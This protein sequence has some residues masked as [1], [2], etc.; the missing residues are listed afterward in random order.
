MIPTM[1]EQIELFD[2]PVVDVSTQEAFCHAVTE[3][4]LDDQSLVWAQRRAFMANASSYVII[5]V[6][7]LTI[8]PKWRHYVDAQGLIDVIAASPKHDLFVKLYDDRVVKAAQHVSELLSDTEI[9][10]LYSYYN[11]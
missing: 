6:D 5:P 1:T 11:N 4:K 7:Q 2:T 9:E 8:I 10:Q 3:N